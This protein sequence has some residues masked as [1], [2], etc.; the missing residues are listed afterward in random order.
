MFGE[1]RSAV[2]HSRR[3]VVERQTRPRGWNRRAGTG[4]LLGANLRGGRTLSSK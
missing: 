1:V 4:C 3:V 2:G